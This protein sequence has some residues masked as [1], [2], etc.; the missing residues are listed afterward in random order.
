MFDGFYQSL[1]AFYMPYLLYSDANF[2]RPDGLGIDDRPRMGVVIG[3]C[4]VLASN[5]Y[6]LLN[7]YRWDWLTVLI[8]CF[9]NLLIYFFGPVLP[10]CLRGLQCSD[11][12][13]CATCDRDRVSPPTFRG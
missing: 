8:N 6:I 13:D 3:T 10:R 9:S 4:A 7:T 2:Q 11:L 1:M 12:L 5:L